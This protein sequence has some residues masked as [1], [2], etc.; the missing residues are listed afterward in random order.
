MKYLIVLSMI[1]IFSCGETDAEKFKRMCPQKFKYTANH[2][3]KVPV[4]ISPHKLSYSIGD[5]LIISTYFSDSIEDLS[6]E[7]TYLIQGFPF[8]PES[9]LWRFSKGTNWDSGFRVNEWSI[10]SIYRPNYNYSNY[11]A[12]N[13]RAYTQYEDNMY[14]FKIQIILKEKGRYIFI[15]SDKYQDYNAGGSPELNKEANEIDFEGKCPFSNFYICTMIED[16]DHLE[17]FEQ[18]LLHLDKEVYSDNLASI[19]R[20]EWPGTY[21]KGSIFLEWVGAFGF[22]VE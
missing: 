6:T 8:K 9:F 22:I 11:F 20:K 15:M 4:Q 1:T 10:D 17:L 13:I 21:G 5:T 3:L 19:N 12:D 14:N 16:E 18:E 2:Y 7:M